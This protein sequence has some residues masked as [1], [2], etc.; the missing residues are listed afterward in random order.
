VRE[1]VVGGEFVCARSGVEL[2]VEELR[3]KDLACERGACGRVAWG[4]GACARVVC[5]SVGG[6]R[7]VCVC[8]R[9]WYVK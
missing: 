2:L 9:A 1:R 8:E 6:D 7:D 4:R 5:E 3:V